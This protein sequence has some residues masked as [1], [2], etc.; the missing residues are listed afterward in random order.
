MTVKMMRAAVVREFG[1]LICIEKRPVPVPGRDQVL[2]RVIASGVCHTDLHA[3]DGDWP[4]KPM[5]PLVPGHEAV[6]IVVA[7]GSDVKG[8]AEGDRVGVPWLHSACGNCEHCSTGWETLC[9]RQH[10]TG[11]SIDGGY[12]DYLLADPRYVGRLPSRMS[13][14]EA[15]PLMCAGVTA[16]KGLK[17]TEAKPGEWVVVVGVGGLGHLAVQYA[18][19]MGF[20]VAAIDV[21]DEKVALGL[22]LGADIG[23]NACTSNVVAEINKSIGGAHGVLVTAISMS[24]FE[25]AIA[26]TRR[27]GT[28]TLVGLPP[29]ECRTPVFDVVRKRIT[30]RGSIG[31]TREDLEEAMAIADASRISARVEVQPFEAINSVLARLRKGDV[32]GRFVLQLAPE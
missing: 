12:A 8:I 11:Y 3:V 21:T 17:E 28:C 18:K 13:F 2:V 15:A 10:N 9:R 19:V 14:R 29:G 1:K 30:I 6:G 27:G 23:L 24:A 5:L 31:G 4:I 26:M 16:Y 22:R 25:Q 32:Q 7:C 20:R